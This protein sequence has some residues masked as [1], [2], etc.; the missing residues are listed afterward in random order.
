[1]KH[2]ARARVL[3]TAAAIA[4]PLAAS[5]PASA[6]DA[7]A[8]THYTA[9]YSMDFT[10]GTAPGYTG[11]A[12]LGF[13]NCTGVR[14]VNAHF[15]RDNWT[16]TT[17]ATDVTATFDPDIPWPCGCSDWASDYDGQV[18]TNYEVDIADGVVDGW[19]IYC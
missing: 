10:G 16:C 4:V 9:A 18:A 11:P 19:A 6:A 13:W 15:V 17:T 12:D 5:A 14:V 7:G 2:L 3:I 8:A 1:M